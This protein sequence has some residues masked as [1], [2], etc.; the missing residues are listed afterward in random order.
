[1]AWRAY[2]IVFKARSPVHVG[3]HTLG[4]IKLTRPYITGRA[5]WG[6]M[7]ANKARSNPNNH[8]FPDY[9]G[10]GDLFRSDIITSYFYPALDPQKPMLPKFTDEGI[11]IG[12]YNRNEFEKIFIRSFGQTGIGPVTNT[13]EEETLHESEFISPIVE[14]DS[15][16][17]KQQVYFTGYLFL[18]DKA[19]Y[20]KEKI[21]WEN[22]VPALS[23]LYVG[24][25][26]KYGWGRLSLDHTL[27]KEVKDKKFFGHDI[28]L[29]NEKLNVTIQKGKPIPAH[30]AIASTVALD[31]SGDVEPLVGREW[32]RVIGY[33]KKENIGFG[34]KISKATLCWVPGSI[35]EKDM[36]FS[37]N[38][39]GL[40]NAVE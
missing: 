12:E 34:R 32:G 10:I 2:Q 29:K 17:E 21:K 13:A 15:K 14:S 40:L 9:E 20:N 28:D 11:K 27:T 24:G 18:N 26:R 22:L 38:E 8:N 19:E 4:Y 25:D 33:D 31:L 3:W 23:E 39:F 6:A 5:M 35:V 7:T 1:M 16:E 36:M 37:I 30:L